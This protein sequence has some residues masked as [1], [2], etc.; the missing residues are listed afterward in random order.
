MRFQ[1]LAA[2]QVAVLIF[3]VVMP[4]GHVGRCGTNV[5]EEDTAAIFRV[6]WYLPTSPHGVT[7][8][9]QYR[10][11]CVFSDYLLVDP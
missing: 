1:V 3:W 7:T 6:R 5:W 11:V 10:Q 8:Q 2:V 9:S 4:C